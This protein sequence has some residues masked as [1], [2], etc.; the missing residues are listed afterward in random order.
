MMDH[1]NVI[2]GY[3][4]LGTEENGALILNT[5]QLYYWHIHKRFRRDEETPIQKG[6]IVKV[7]TSRGPKQV[8]V[9]D[10]FREDNTV[11]KKQ[12]K[13]VKEIIERAPETDKEK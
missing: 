10:I 1:R 6:D 5:D 8:L 13:Q 4:I 12:Y 3:H 11:D 7:M 2:A 9:M